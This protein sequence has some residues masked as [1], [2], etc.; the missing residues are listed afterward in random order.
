MRSAIKT[1]NYE[2][3]KSP[4][5]GS[6]KVLEGTPF[7]NCCWT[8]GLQ[9]AKP[10]KFHWIFKELPTIL[11]TGLLKTH[12]GAY[13]IVPR[14]VPTTQLLKSTDPEHFPS[15]FPGKHSPH[16]LQGGTAPP[17]MSVY[18]VRRPHRTAY[19]HQDDSKA[20]IHSPAVAF[21]CRAQTIAL[22]L[23]VCW[24]NTGCFAWTASVNAAGQLPGLLHGRSCEHIHI[25]SITFFAPTIWPT[26]GYW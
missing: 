5:S 17:V 25:V 16:R 26:V 4:L 22:R 10:I 6:A 19:G 11:V 24:T 1:I 13:S 9:T 18:G 21:V 20:V 15:W 3:K 7:Q 8:T 23:S 2:H 14:V 12:W